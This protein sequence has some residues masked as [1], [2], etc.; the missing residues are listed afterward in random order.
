MNAI[1]KSE[2]RKKDQEKHR[3]VSFFRKDMT[4]T[5]RKESQRLKQEKAIMFEENSQHD[6]HIRSGKCKY[7]NEVTQLRK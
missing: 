2:K 6:K 1:R 4:R 5:H 7:V 3:R